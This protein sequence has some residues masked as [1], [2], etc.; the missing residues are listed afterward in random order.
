MDEIIEKI[1][2]IEKEAAL[3]SCSTDEAKK[4]MAGS[5]EKEIAEMES[6]LKSRA[7]KK[8]EA[9][10][11]FEAKEAEKEIA[12]ILK[13]RDASIARLEKL[14]AEKK[15]EWVRQIVDSVTGVK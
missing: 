12:E 9:I 15:D 6:E 14:Y 11:E 7:E 13:K 3:L 10:R 1:I 4:N 2:K 8:K 5:I